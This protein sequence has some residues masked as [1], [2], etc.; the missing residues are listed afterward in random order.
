LRER[1]REREINFAD[2]GDDY[3]GGDDDD[4]G[5]DGDDDVSIKIV[6]KYSVRTF[7]CPN[8]LSRP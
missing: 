4:N 3:G 7:Q 6:S 8:Q 1:E 2:Y 5:G